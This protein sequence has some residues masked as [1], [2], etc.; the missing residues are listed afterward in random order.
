M[1]NVKRTL[2]EALQTYT[3]MVMILASEPVDHCNALEWSLAELCQG[4]GWQHTM[5]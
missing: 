1:T 4:L 3:D 5:G 2:T